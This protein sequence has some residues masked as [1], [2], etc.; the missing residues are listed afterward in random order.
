MLSKKSLQIENIFL[1]LMSYG[2][3]LTFV[4]EEMTIKWMRE[5]KKATRDYFY[6]LYYVLWHN[7][8]LELLL[9]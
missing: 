7:E 2:D 4:Y 6:L 8:L 1:P 9:L 3:F 5:M